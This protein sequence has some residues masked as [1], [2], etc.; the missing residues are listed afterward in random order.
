M[1]PSSPTITTTRA[2][3]WQKLQLSALTATVLLA[4]AVPTVS[5]QAQADCRLLLQGYGNNS[6]STTSSSRSGNST[7]RDKLGVA[8]AWLSCNSSDGA[9]LPVAINETY[10]QQHAAA[11]TGVKIL[12]ASACKADAAAALPSPIYALLYFCS[13]DHHIKLQQPVIQNLRLP[14]LAAGS[15]SSSSG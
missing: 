10:L 14:P 11:F 8:V 15:N 13:S 9:L 7:G 1:A 6:S 3:Y 4:I 12:A 2:R 5:C